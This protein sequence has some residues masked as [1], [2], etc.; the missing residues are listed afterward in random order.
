[1]VDGKRKE[2]MGMH[3]HRP[4]LYAARAPWEGVGYFAKHVYKLCITWG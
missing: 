1:M 3:T 4:A 2:E